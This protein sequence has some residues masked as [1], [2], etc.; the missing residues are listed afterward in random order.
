MQQSQGMSQIMADMMVR[1]NKPKKILRHFADFQKRHMK[2]KELLPQTPETL[3]LK[4]NGY[5]SFK[6]DAKEL[7]ELLEACKKLYAQADQ[8]ATTKSKGF[9]KQL[10]SP[11][12]YDAQ[13]I[14]IRFALNQ[15]ILQ[16]ISLYLGAV[17]FLEWVE[18]I[19][20]NPVD[21]PLVKSQLW[22]KD[23]TD[24]KMIK[25][26]INIFDVDETH[27]P[28]SF[29]PIQASKRVP[30][31]KN[32]MS[33]YLSDDQIAAWID[34]AQKLQY[35]SPTGPALMLDT[36]NCYHMGSRCKQPRVVY[37]AYYSTG[38]GYYARHYPVKKVDWQKLPNLENAGLN[39][40]QK[41]V[42]GL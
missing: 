7:E 21:A 40:L 22:H 25:V 9:V 35:T 8:I 34:P 28:L 15:D 4:E 23:G 31:H 26:F 32:L 19:N 11:E 27:G 18:V 24:N 12:Q 41:M 42:L 5:L 36:A 29:Y 2:A 20:S 14:L 10:A 30:L 33:H 13:D 17:P 16:K 1:F 37:C 38:F 3:S 6:P 39:D